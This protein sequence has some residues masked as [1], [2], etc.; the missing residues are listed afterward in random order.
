MRPS[1]VIS[2]L[3]GLLPV[4]LSSICITPPE[5]RPDRLSSP[6]FYNSETVAGQFDNEYHEMIYLQWQ[7]DSTDTIPVISYKIIRQV[8]IDSF[9]T[10][11]TSIPADVNDLYDPTYK[12]VDADDRTNDRLIFYR[13][14]AID[15][16]DEG[17]PGDTSAVCTVS[18]A[19]VVDLLSPLIDTISNQSSNFKW[20]V[21]SINNPIKTYVVLWL[22]DSTLWVSDTIKDFTGGGPKTYERTLPS[23]LLPLYSG[24]YFWGGFLVIQGGSVNGDDASSVAIRNFYVK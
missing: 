16:I 21:P 24:V 12:F 13:I 23:S 10:F 18:L 11:I 3:V 2:I 15:G 6:V 9:Q 22:N 14:F 4:L 1:L 20:Q 19:R 17:R 7:P 8:D 5:P